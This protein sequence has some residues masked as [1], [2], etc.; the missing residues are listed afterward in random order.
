[1]YY[2][3]NINNYN[4]GISKILWF[5]NNYVDEFKDC[6]TNLVGI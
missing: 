5:I 2:M 4:L 6:L 3:F 1:M